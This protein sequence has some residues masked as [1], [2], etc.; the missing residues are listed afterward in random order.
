MFFVSRIITQDAP[1]G[2]DV[3]CRC[4]WPPIGLLVL[5]GRTDTKTASGRVGC[6]RGWPPFGGLQGVD[7]RRRFA[8]LASFTAV[9]W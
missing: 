2:G 1:E 9:G 5:N 8:S 6:L 3:A 4:L 7:P